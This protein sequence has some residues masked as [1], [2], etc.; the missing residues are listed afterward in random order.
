MPPRTENVDKGI[1]DIHCLTLVT[2]KLSVPFRG[3]L[4]ILLD[5]MGCSK[6]A[7]SFQIIII[8]GIPL[9]V[10]PARGRLGIHVLAPSSKLLVDCA[11]SIKEQRPYQLQPLGNSQSESLVF[12]T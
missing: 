6:E 3:Y 1:L 7:A 11:C 12:S 8:T 2:F 4:L 10:I 5:L 9:N